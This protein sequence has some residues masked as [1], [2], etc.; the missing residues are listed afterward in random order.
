MRNLFGFGQDDSQQGT[1]KNQSYLKST[2][3]INM[4]MTLDGK[5]AR[6]DGKWYGLSSKTDKMQ[7]D[8]YR[9][10]SDTLII[11]KNS[12]INDDPVIRIRYVENAKNPRPVI[13]V[14]NG[15]IPKNRKV[16][17]LAAER[18]YV[19][20]NSLNF[21]VVSDTL[22]GIAEVI[23]FKS[24]E[25]RP[26]EVI[27]FLSEKGYHRILLEGGPRLN[28]SFMQAGVINRIYLTIVPYVIGKRNLPS[29]VDGE[30]EFSLFEKKEWRLTQ[31][32]AIE[33]EIFLT[34][35]RI[36]NS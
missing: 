33:D 32:K 18:P 16:F 3:S 7:M 27:R 23:E 31:S 4:A 19:I 5:I 8:I 20:C 14:R 11:G 25:L 30:I 24:D 22:G 6:P 21:L 17:E 28:Y 10:V 15:T 35:D 26:E 9:S 13:L 2:V 29:I 1:L 36:G 34:Y 12:I